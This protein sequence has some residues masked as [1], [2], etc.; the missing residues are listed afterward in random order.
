MSSPLQALDLYKEVIKQHP[1]NIYALNGIGT[2]L[3]GE[4]KPAAAAAVAADAAAVAAAAAEA[5][6]A[7]PCTC[8]HEQDNKVP[9][10]CTCL[11]VVCTHQV[12]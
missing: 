11:H 7:S 8:L 10:F 9:G 12:A 5:E 6:A 4:H 1:D 2:C 3:A